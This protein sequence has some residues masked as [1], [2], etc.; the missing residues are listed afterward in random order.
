MTWEELCEKAKEM[1]L[2][3]SEENSMEP[4]YI[5]FGNLLFTQHSQIILSD[6]AYDL[7]LCCVNHLVRNDRTPKQM[8][9]IMEALR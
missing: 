5:K 3:V 9:Q 4:A 8:Y 2:F 1:G 6:T 7:D